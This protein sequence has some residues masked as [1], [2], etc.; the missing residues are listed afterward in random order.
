MHL[1]LHYKCFKGTGVRSVFPFVFGHRAVRSHPE[2]WRLCLP[3]LPVQKAICVVMLLLIDVYNLFPCKFRNKCFSLLMG[4]DASINMYFPTAAVVSSAGP[5]PC[6]P[7]TSCHRLSAYYVRG[8]ILNT[9][10]AWSHL[11]RH[12]HPFS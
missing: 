2:D 5:G 8:A 10:H 12:H 6:F 7:I 4:L 9:F 11:M 1:K 3:G